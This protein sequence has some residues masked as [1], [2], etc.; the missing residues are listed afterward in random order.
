MDIE[1]IYEVHKRSKDKINLVYQRA[2]GKCGHCYIDPT[3]PLRW[4]KGVANYGYTASNLA[5]L[6]S[7]AKDSEFKVGVWKQ[8]SKVEIFVKPVNLWIHSKNTEAIV[9]ILY[10][11][12]NRM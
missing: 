8:S 6:L 7:H 3:K 5:E 2:S 4:T 10:G 1:E 12:I 9:K 11:K